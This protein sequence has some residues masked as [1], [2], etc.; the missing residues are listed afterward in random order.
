MRHWKI[1]LMRDGRSQRQ[2]HLRGDKVTVGSHPSCNVRL[3]RPAPE[4]LATLEG[5]LPDACEFGWDDSVVLV[6][7]VTSGM[8]SLLRQ[9]KVRIGSEPE[10]EAVSG[11][12]LSL[13]LVGLC[14][15]LL[16]ALLAPFLADQRPQMLRT[17]QAVVAQQEIESLELSSVSQPALEPTRPHASLPGGIPA[18]VPLALVMG[19]GTDLSKLL[20]ADGSASHPSNGGKHAANQDMI[21]VAMS[22]RMDSSSSSHRSPDAQFYRSPELSGLFEPG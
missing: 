3:P 18:R 16:A 6:E 19:I 10:R 4:V 5:A 15:L 12:K 1:T 21:L 13:S 11:Q 2:W 7:D 8:N 17:L 20:R 9:A 14:L 22:F